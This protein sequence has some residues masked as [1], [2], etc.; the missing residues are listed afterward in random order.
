MDKKNSELLQNEPIETDFDMSKRG[1][2]IV[3]KGHNIL[4]QQR[5]DSIME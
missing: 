4:E 2:V 5:M 1:T 3:E